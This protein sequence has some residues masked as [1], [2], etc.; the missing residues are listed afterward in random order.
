MNHH[1]HYGDWTIEWREEDPDR[2]KFWITTLFVFPGH[3]RVETF[4]L[5]VQ[6]FETPE[7]GCYRCKRIIDLIV[8]EQRE[9]FSRVT[10]EYLDSLKPPAPELQPIDS[11]R[12]ADDGVP[13]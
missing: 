10:T 8:R 5:F 9:L 6:C 4:N 7:M 13:F 3:G 1:E 2:I 11:D 12:Q